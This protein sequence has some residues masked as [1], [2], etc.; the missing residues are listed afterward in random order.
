[1]RGDRLHLEVVGHDDAFVAEFRSSKRLS[2]PATTTWR[3]LLVELA[4]HDVGV[5]MVATFAAIAL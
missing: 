3:N 4:H 1:M 2:Q 5:M